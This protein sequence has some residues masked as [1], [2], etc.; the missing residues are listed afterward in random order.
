MNFFLAAGEDVMV[1]SGD[2]AIQSVL[3]EPM[4]SFSVTDNFSVTD[5]FSVTDDFSDGLLS[6]WDVNRLHKKE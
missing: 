4:G 1:V 6:F 2:G 5:G 3:S